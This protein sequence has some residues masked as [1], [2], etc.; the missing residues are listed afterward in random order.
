M[1]ELARRAPEALIPGV[2]GPAVIAHSAGNTVRGVR[3]ALAEIADFLEIDLYVHEGRFE[4]RHE[5]RIYPFPLLFEKWYLRLAPRQ[6]YG[7]AEALREVRGSARIFLDLKDGGSRA[8]QL[9]RRSLDEAPGAQLAA[10]SQHWPI[11][12]ALQRICPEVPLFYSIDVQAKLDLMLAVSGR[13]LLPAGV[14]CHHRLLTA[15]TVRLLH[16]AGLSVVAYTVDDLE[17]ARELIAWGVEGITTHKV[18]DLR[19]LL[20]G[21]V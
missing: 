6:P 20:E 18:K 15:T 8:A 1:P 14:S 16:E 5:R 7:L 17:R 9:V 11:L 12:R 3:I 21:R 19:G 2:M 4:A 13:D 10:S